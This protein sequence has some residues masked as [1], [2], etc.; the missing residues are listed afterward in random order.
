MTK[1]A[2]LFGYNPDL[3]LTRRRIDEW[4]HAMQDEFDESGKVAC[5]KDDGWT[6]AN[7]H[8]EVGDEAFL[9]RHGRY[10]ERGIIGHGVV[11]WPLFEDTAY[12][13]NNPYWRAPIEW[14]VLKMH[15]A[16]LIGMDALRR[17]D[18]PWGSQSSGVRIKPA[19]AKALRAIWRGR[20]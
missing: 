16:P 2:Y 11:V 17:I 5:S 8:V 12:K 6:C 3:Q 9:F 10:L 4:A 1:V 18:G 15:G 19:A 14:D 13:T 20:S 7:H